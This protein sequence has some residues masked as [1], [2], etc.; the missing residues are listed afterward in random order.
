MARQAVNDGRIRVHVLDMLGQNVRKE[1]CRMSMISKPSYLRGSAPQDVV[2]F[3]WDCI[4]HELQEKA[5]TLYSLLHS[6]TSVTISP[7][8]ARKTSR[9]AKQI[10]I[11]G[12]CA[13]I[14]LQCRCHSMNL[15][16]RL[17][18]ILLYNG[19]ASKQVRRR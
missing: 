11:I 19:G 5:P 2:S 12:I 14:L 8:K 13:A 1:M 10:P 15:V 9:R 17:L 3:S 7:S 18:S 4:V 6:A 16:Q